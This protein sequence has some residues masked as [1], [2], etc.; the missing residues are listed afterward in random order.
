MQ[1][2]F[3]N[4]SSLSGVYNLEDNPSKTRE[5]YKEFTNAINKNRK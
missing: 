1:E 3:L 4:Q 2:D 5:F